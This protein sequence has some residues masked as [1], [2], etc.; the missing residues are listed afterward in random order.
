MDDQE[1]HTPLQSIFSSTDVVQVNLSAATGDMGILANHEPSIE[2]LRP[3]VVE[4]VESGNTSKK[5]FST[6]PSFMWLWTPPIT[7]TFYSL[8]RVCYSAPQQQIDHQRRGSGTFGCVL[9]RGMHLLA[10][11]FATIL[12]YPGR[13]YDQI[14]KR[15]CESRQETGRRR[16]N[17]KLVLRRMSTK[18]CSMPWATNCWTVSPHIS[19][20]C[21]T[22]PA[23]RIGRMSDRSALC[24]EFHFV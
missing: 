4:V 10:F 2:P 18:L 9:P 3:G 17:L 20:L 23:Y 21:L 8:W 12:T 11:I 1:T 13:L 22:T 16:I 7:D 15:H 6:C 5:W 14:S 24:R 19:L